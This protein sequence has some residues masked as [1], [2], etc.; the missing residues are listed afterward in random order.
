MNELELWVDVEGEPQGQPRPAPPTRDPAAV[1][2]ARLVAYA[3]GVMRLPRERQ[4]P[5]HLRV[6]RR[7]P[8]TPPRPR[9]SAASRSTS[10]CPSAPGPGRGRPSSTLDD[11]TL[12]EADRRRREVH[13]ALF[14]GDAQRVFDLVRLRWEEMDRAYPGRDD[15]AD[16]PEPRRL[17]R[18][19]RRRPAP[20]RPARS[21][22]P[23]L[24]PRRR[25]PDDR[26]HR[27]GLLPLDPHRPGGRARPLGRRALPPLPGPDRRPAHRRAL[28]PRGRWP[29][30][31]NEGHTRAPAPRQVE[32]P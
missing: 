29:P 16:R 17:D 12:R 24:P 14:G 27:R 13:A 1:A 19:A 8:T 22:A 31:H 28:S 18:R 20:P 2:V 21:C 5:R 11:L 25:R 30:V 6:P 7:R 32:H 9:A 26:V 23:R 3:A 15:A 10:A 4:G